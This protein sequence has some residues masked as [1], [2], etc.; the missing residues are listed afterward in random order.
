MDHDLTSLAET[1]TQADDLSQTDG[2]CK[3][4][5]NGWMPI[6]NIL[7]V[8]LGLNLRPHLLGIHVLLN[9]SLYCALVM[10]WRWEHQWCHYRHIEIPEAPRTT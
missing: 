4:V 10:W 3:V 7:S 6:L 9:V 8:V 1:H 2:N 5:M